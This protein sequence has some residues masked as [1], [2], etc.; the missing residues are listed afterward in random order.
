MVIGSGIGGGG[1]V[2]KEILDV[3]LVF[4]VGAGVDGCVKAW[5]RVFAIL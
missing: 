3:P 5:W 2:W 4:E 1:V